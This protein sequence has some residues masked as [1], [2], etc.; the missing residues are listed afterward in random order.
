MRF[1][2][3]RLYVQYAW[4]Q[5][6]TWNISL[7]AGLLL[8]IGMGYLLQRSDVATYRSLEAD[9]ASVKAELLANS[10]KKSSAAKDQEMQKQEQFLGLLADRKYLE[11]EVKRV[12]AIA[13]QSELVVRSGEYKR[14]DVSQGAYL[15]YTMKFPVRGSYLQIRRFVERCLVQMPYASLDELQFKRDAISQ[16]VLE[17]KISFTVYAALERD[18]ALKERFE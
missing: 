8:C 16:S 15:T 14:G 1:S 17:A 4:R 6:G 7:I 10:S 12:L 3:I 2:F 13:Q 9:M 18:A 5:L 11:Q